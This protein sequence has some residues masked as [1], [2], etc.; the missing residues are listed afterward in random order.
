MYSTLL[1]ALLLTAFIGGA[2]RKSQTTKWPKPTL[3]VEFEEQFEPVGSASTRH[4][5]VYE[6]GGTATDYPFS[7]LRPLA[8]AVTPST[9]GDLSLEFA[10][11]AGKVV[12]SV[13]AL[14]PES[15]PLRSSDG[16]KRLLATHSARLNETVALQELKTIGYT[17]FALRIVKAGCKPPILRSAARLPLSS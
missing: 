17:P 10:A 7:S 6:N 2:C 11:K 12:T 8:G 16:H 9:D 15:D 5:N 3:A 14:P 4:V 13:Y 1:S